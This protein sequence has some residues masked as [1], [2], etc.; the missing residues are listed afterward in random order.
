MGEEALTLTKRIMARRTINELQRSTM[1]DAC[2]AGATILIW[3]LFIGA[4]TALAAEESLKPAYVEWFSCDRGPLALRLGRSLNS[5]RGL[6]KVREKVEKVAPDGSEARVLQ[7]DGLTLRVVFPATDHANGLIESAEISNSRWSVSE[8]QV[9]SSVQNLRAR[10]GIAAIP[11][12]SRIKI[13]G[14]ADCVTF[15]IQKERVR[16]IEYACYTG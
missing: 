8:I 7:F 4:S 2:R 11:M 5:L 16:R 6:G 1:S 14:D 15:S 3:V 9:G 12:N 10:V 13:C